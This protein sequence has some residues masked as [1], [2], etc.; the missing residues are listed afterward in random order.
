MI[1]VSSKL[2]QG[3]EKEKG[4][5][6]QRQGKKEKKRDKKGTNCYIFFSSFLDINECFLNIASRCNSKSECVNTN[7]SYY[8]CDS[9]FQA[10]EN[11]TACQGEKNE[12]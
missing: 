8:C 1:K 6:R 4:R 10:N 9:G 2:E 5:T 7:G 11:N 3:K 12:N